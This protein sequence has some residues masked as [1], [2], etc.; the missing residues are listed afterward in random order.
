MSD[1]AY[2]YCSECSD[3]FPVRQSTYDKLEECGNTF[4]CPQGHALVISRTTIVSRFRSEARLSA[5]RLRTIDKFYKREAAIRGV[6]TRQ[7][8]RLLRGACPYCNKTPQDMTK[9]MIAQHGHKAS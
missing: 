6:M 5:C 7:R 3:N 8:N 4:Y 9:H 2:P 1:F